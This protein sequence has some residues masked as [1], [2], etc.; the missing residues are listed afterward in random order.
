VIEA[1]KHAR[2]PLQSE[3]FAMGFAINLGNSMI[4][5]NPKATDEEGNVLC[6]IGIVPGTDYVLFSK[7]TN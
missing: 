2:L 1:V 3:M 5:E 7:M 4:K 6:T